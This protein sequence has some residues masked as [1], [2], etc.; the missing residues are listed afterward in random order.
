[1][2]VFMILGRFCYFQD[3]ISQHFTPKSKKELGQLYFF[4]SPLAVKTLK[5]SKLASK[6]L[7]VICQF[8]PWVKISGET[9]VTKEWQF[10][11]NNLNPMIS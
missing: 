5:Y 4:T 7:A 1:M 8:L 9:C 11:M 10:Q 6:K 2:L 3:T